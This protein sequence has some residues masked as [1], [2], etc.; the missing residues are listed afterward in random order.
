M[1]DHHEAYAKNTVEKTGTL[2]QAT[3]GVDAVV[4]TVTK[5]FLYVNP[6]LLLLNVTVS[7]DVLN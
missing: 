7:E 6:I 2:S 5:T 1:N 3:V 4:E